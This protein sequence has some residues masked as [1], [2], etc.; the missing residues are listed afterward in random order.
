MT[1]KDIETDG[2]MSFYGTAGRSGALAVAVET[3]SEAE[4][5]GIAAGDVIIRWGDKAVSHAGDLHGVGMGER[6][7]VLRK[8]ICTEL[9]R[10]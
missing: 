8:Q 2:E 5:A 4:K 9:P 1:V 3:G 6:V 10:K 7:C